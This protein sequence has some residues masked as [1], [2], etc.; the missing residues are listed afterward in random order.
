MRLPE[1]PGPEASAFIDNRPGRASSGRARTTR[2]PSRKQCVRCCSASAPPAPARQTAACT[3][4]YAGSTACAGAWRPVAAGHATCNTSPVVWESAFIQANSVALTSAGTGA[5]TLAAAHPLQRRAVQRRGERGRH[6]LPARRRAV[7]EVLQRRRARRPA[8]RRRRQVRQ[9]HAAAARRGGRRRHGLRRAAPGWHMPSRMARRSAGSGP[10]PQPSAPPPAV[11]PACQPYRTASMARM[12]AR[13]SKQ[14]L[15]E[16]TVPTSRLSQ[17]PEEQQ[18]KH[19]SPCDSQARS[20]GAPA[21]RRRRPARPAGTRRR[22]RARRT[23]PP[24]PPAAPG[25]CP[26]P[27]RPRAGFLGRLTAT[28]SVAS[29]AT[30]VHAACAGTPHRQRLPQW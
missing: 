10:G 30:A 4:A 3:R 6:K 16:S 28:A 26:P 25:T 9:A 7:Q 8:A 15:L 1:V 29:A 22:P 13:R 18:C 20:G 17:P 23:R 14:T 19:Q 21:G 2:S 5:L 11:A 24:A 27:A 12:S